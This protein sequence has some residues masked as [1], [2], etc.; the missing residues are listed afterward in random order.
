MSHGWGVVAANPWLFAMLGVS[1]AAVNLF[2]FLA[3]RLT[4]SLTF[5]TVGCMKNVFVV[6]LGVLLGDRV[7]GMQLIGYGIAILGFVYY[8]LVQHRARQAQQVA[9][10]G[11]SQKKEQ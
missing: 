8:T 10:P 5:K 4:S 7:S 1:S 11:T 6:W 9:A 3:I 2:S